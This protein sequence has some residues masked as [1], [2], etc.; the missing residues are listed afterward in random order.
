MS[1]QELDNGKNA[2]AL[3]LARQ[4]IDDQTTEIAEMESLL[5]EL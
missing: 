2:D 1:Q 4:I 5:S 3:E